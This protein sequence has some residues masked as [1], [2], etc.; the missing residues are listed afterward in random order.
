[1]FTYYLITREAALLP[2]AKLFDPKD[3]SFGLF[4]DVISTRH[5]G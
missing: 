5:Y 3:Y 1:M 2:I 4:S